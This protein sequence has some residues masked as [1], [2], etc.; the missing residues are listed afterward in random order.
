MLGGLCKNPRGTI[1]PPK[2]IHPPILQVAPAKK[3]YKFRTY[4]SHTISFFL[5]PILHEAIATTY[6]NS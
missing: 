1:V 6:H 3:Q 4:N 2:R 5:Y